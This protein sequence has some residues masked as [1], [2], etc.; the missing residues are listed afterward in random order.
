MSS[1]KGLTSTKLRKGEAHIVFS[2]MMMK[3]KASATV[4]AQANFNKMN[5][6]LA[7]ARTSALANFKEVLNSIL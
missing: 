1:I 7:K 4:N 3:V 5:A 6:K 2:C